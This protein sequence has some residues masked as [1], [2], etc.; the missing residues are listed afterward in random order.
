MLVGQS[1]MTGGLRI[2]SFLRAFS[3]SL[4][5]LGKFLCE[6]TSPQRH[7][8]T[9]NARRSSKLR[10][11]LPPVL[12][13]FLTAILLASVAN[14]Q[15][16]TGGWAR[17]RTGTLAW[18]H[19][20]FFVNQ[21]RGWAVGSKGTLLITEDGG[22]TWQQ[23]Y[24]PTED[25]IRDIYFLDETTGWI[26]CERNIYDLKNVDEPRTYLMNTT[27]GGQRWNRVNVRGADVDKRLVRAVFG[28]GGRAWAFG[29]GG[30]IYSTRD[31][32]V[33]WTKLTVPTRH[34]LLGGTFIDDDRGWLV[35]A[36]ATILQTSD[37]G[38]TW[39]LSRLTG[40]EGTRFTATSFVD[41]RLGWAVGSGGTIY[42]TING[43]RIWSPQNSG[44]SADLLDVKFLDASEGW[45]VGTD[46]TVI[47]T[48]DGGLHWTAER[49]GISHPLE[50]I[51]FLDR[52]HGWAVGFGGT[53]MSYVRAE[54]PSLRR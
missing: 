20:I 7:R 2:H 34:L 45:A 5:L 28:S 39:H 35:G 21:N 16:Q 32:G 1:L 30:A 36:G 8:G 3:V 50:R 47:Y 53:V 54:A 41:N 24:R 26:V 4:C 29:E 52:T 42:R 22:K 43:G 37:G 13:F 14:V 18:L 25:V 46:G 31:S 49:T 51:F 17:Q 12:G 44:V 19:S 9:E 11:S 40:A 10:H 23:K 33:N 38:E 6:V 48:R 15:A 27:D